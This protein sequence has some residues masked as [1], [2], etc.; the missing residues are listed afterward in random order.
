MKINRTSRVLRNIGLPLATAGFMIFTAPS[1]SEAS[2]L[3]SKLLHKGMDSEQVQTLQ[4][5]L[6][7]KGLYEDIQVNGVYDKNTSQA[8]RSFQEKHNLMVDGIAGPQTFG[9]LT[10]LSEGDKGVLVEDLQERLQNLGYYQGN[11]DGLFGP[12]THIAVTSFQTSQGIMVDG[13]AGPQT[14]AALFNYKAQ[15]VEPKQEAQAAPVTAKEEPVEEPAESP[16]PVESSEPVEEPV[17]SSEPAESPEPAENPEPVV[18]E[19]ATEQVEQSAPVS[20]NEAPAE[21]NQATFEMEATAYTAYCDGCS[22]V[23]AT[24]IDLRNNPNKKVIAVDPSVIP[25]GTRV[26]VEGYG[27]AV[28]GDTGGAIQGNKVDLHFPT[29]EEAIQFGRQTVTVTIID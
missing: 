16:E 1:I 15:V 29:K 13:L 3:G 27:E 19:A 5:L 4:E 12:L 6:T 28:A 23:T 14:Y 18:T 26:H 11:L 8:I 17:E 25:L 22:G 24:G 20:N 9:A 10:V 7:E 21:D 2:E